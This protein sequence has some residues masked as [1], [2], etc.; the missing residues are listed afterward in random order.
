MLT[1][2]QMKYIVRLA[3]LDELMF[4]ELEDPESAVS[5]MVNAFTLNFLLKNTPMGKRE[6]LVGM[7]SKQSDQAEL[8]KFIAEN[9]A[10]FEKRYE[11]ALRDQLTKIREETLNH[12]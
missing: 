5:D 6:E 2:D 4:E 12:E 11:S 7:T 10:D 1:T 9:I 3:N 8:W